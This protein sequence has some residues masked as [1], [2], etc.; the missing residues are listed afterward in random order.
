MP[1]GEWIKGPLK[2]WAEDTIATLDPGRY[3]VSGAQQ[4][5]ADHIA[6]KANHTREL[7]T[8]L[9]TARWMQNFSAGTSGS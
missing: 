4:M 1:I 9:M 8:L 2:G 7:R 3:N 6:E 5:L